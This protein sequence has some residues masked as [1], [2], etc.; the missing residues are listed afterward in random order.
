[1]RLLDHHTVNAQ[2]K[3]RP[4]RVGV[5]PAPYHPDPEG[6]GFARS[7]TIY[8]D[9]S[10]GMCSASAR[11]LRRFVSPHGFVLVP[12]QDPGAAQILGLAPGVIPDEMKLRT[13]DGQILGGADAL[14]YV[15]RLVWWMWP[16]WAMLRVPGM[17]TLLH[18]LYRKLASNR[19]RFSG[20][21]RI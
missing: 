17:K 14:L 2:N 18:R 16:I 8:F 5:T 19:H 1:M 15:A 6:S 20:A 4:F 3:A 10:C 11:R 13:H 12:L 7:G 21:C 9:A